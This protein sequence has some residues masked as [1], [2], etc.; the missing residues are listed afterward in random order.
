MDWFSK[1]KVV[2]ESNW[3][4]TKRSCFGK[5]PYDSKY[6][7]LYDSM[8]KIVNLKK[9]F[10]WHERYDLENIIEKF[11]VWGEFPTNDYLLLDYENRIGEINQRADLIY[12]RNDGKV[13]PC[14]LKIGGDSKDTHGQL[15]RYMASLAEEKINKQWVDDIFNSYLKK[16]AKRNLKSKKNNYAIEN[17]LK[18]N[19]VIKFRK[20]NFK[21]F[22]QKNDITSFSFDFLNKSGLI[23]DEDFTPQLTSAI[24]YLNNYCG[25]SIKLFKITTYVQDD[26]DI[27]FDDINKDL[28]YKITI[29]EYV[30]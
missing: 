13:I 11:E 10:K 9:D 20:D 29:D 17:E 28:F 1:I 25:F 4:I 27:N 19:L 30:E 8:S 6:K 16:I 15:I 5:Q 2:G 12:L 21:E 22:I 23:F 3:E 24:N 7:K 14:E 26:F 18:T